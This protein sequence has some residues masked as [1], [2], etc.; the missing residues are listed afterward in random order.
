[1]VYKVLL[2]GEGKRFG[3]STSTPYITLAG[4]LG[5]TGVIE[6]PRGDN[7]VEIT[8]QNIG[9]LTC[10][11]VGHDNSGIAPSLLLEM[12]LVHNKTT[13]QIYRLVN[14]LRCDI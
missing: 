10:L 12:V 11:R 2:V 4:Y 8:H 9:P 14:R 1:M 6:I 13:G 7:H 3:L 5:D